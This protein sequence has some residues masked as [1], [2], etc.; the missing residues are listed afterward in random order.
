LKSAVHDAFGSNTIPEDSTQ[1]QAVYGFMEG[2][3]EGSEGNKWFVADYVKRLHKTENERKP[4]R[5][6]KCGR[7][8]LLSMFLPFL[9]LVSFGADTTKNLRR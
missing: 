6:T 5:A 4:A 1:F 7:K 9:P 8:E 2:S 3:Q